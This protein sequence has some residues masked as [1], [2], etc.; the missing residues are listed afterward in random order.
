[1]NPCVLKTHVQDRLIEKRE[2][3]AELTSAFIDAKKGCMLLNECS[4]SAVPLFDRLT[5]NSCC[6]GILDANGL[7]KE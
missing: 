3:T 4:D 5:F 6:Q 2:E 1:M 7:D